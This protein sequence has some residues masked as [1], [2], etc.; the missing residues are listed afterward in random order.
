MKFFRN[1]AYWI[2][3]I[4]I[5]SIIL[6]QCNQP[7]TNETGNIVPDIADHTP[8]ATKL[9][10][11]DAA[12]SGKSHAEI[13]T[14]RRPVRINADARNNPAL[15]NLGSIPPITECVTEPPPP[16]PTDVLKRRDLMLRELVVA[17]KL[18]EEFEDGTHVLTAEAK[19]TELEAL[20]DG[21][22]PEDAVAFLEKHD[23][24]TIPS[25]IIR[26]LVFV[27]FDE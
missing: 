15:K 26:G 21:M 6:I 13:S 3:G 8:D 1:N 22:N 19:Q 16:L 17:G 7:Q 25:P 9:Q 23:I 27:A 20:T 18:F 5:S 12:P 14:K 2:L 11:S 24:Y 10:P 4:G